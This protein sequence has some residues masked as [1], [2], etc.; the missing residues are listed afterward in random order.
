MPT[1]RTQ[2]LVPL[3][4]V[5]EG[6]EDVPQRLRLNPREHAADGVRAGQGRA[7]PPS[8]EGPSPILFQGIEAAPANQHH[9]ERRPG[10]RRGR[11]VRIPRES[12]RVFRR[13]AATIP[14]EAATHSDGKAATFRPVV[15]KVAGMARNTHPTQHD[16][17][18]RVSPTPIHGDKARYLA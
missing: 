18:S 11:I 15:G 9:E 14:S 4:P 2:S 6:V 3:E 8:P 1:A 5:V 7:Q 16:P 17:P 10:D 13:K 12:G